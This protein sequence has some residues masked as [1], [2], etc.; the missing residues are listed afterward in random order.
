MATSVFLASD[1][2]SWYNRINAVRQRPGISI[3]AIDVPNVQNTL[4]RAAT[5]DEF[6]SQILALKS[7][8]HLKKADYTGI[9]NLNIS[10]GVAKLESQKI[11]IDSTIQ[12]LEGICANKVTTQCSNKTDNSQCSDRTD[13]S[14]HSDYSDNGR[15][16]D[17]D[18]SRNS[19]DYDYSR[20]TDECAD[21]SRNTDWVTNC[22]VQTEYSNDSDMNTTSDGDNRDY[23]D[24]TDK[25]EYSDTTDSDD[26]DYS[27]NTNYSDYT[28]YSKNTVVCSDQSIC[29]TFAQTGNSVTT[30]TV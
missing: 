3:G 26:R 8:T 9:E 13:D 20:Y 25:S 10:S 19:D 15:T 1:L 11:N 29:S 4:A 22:P 27:D 14:Q 6:K 21:R 7:N 16:T 17:S 30:Y 23:T 18:N 5:M 12:S 24:Y 2:T 28:N